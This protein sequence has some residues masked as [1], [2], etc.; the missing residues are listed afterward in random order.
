MRV[1]CI[2][3]DGITGYVKF[4]DLFSSINIPNSF[5]LM[6]TVK[7]LETDTTKNYRPIGISNVFNIGI[8]AN[9]YRPFIS[10]DKNDAGHGSVP[11]VSG[12]VDRN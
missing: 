2:E 6:A 11:N 10:T 4:A 9:Q 7:F 12:S 8:N 3:T 5:T 1:N